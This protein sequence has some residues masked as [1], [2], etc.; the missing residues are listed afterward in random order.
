[1]DP[2]RSGALTISFREP[3]TEDGASVFKLVGECPPLDPNSMYCNLLQCSHFASTSVAAV[4]DDGNLV[5]FIS[6]Y[7]IPE[8]PHVL[9]VWQVAV[10]QVARGRKLASRMLQEIL[11]RP[12]CRSVT[13]IETSITESNRASW[14]L[15]HKLAASLD[16]QLATSTLFD[17]TRHFNQ[18]H[19]TEVLVA[20]GPFESVANRNRQAKCSA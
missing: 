15:F 18:Q 7:L 20:I 19:D 11:R 12:Q 13:H 14:A 3:V 6:A 5:G 2:G 1:M 9:F 17:K 4:D 10:A 8:R 16:A